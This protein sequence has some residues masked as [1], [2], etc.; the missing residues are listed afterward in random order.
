MNLISRN[1]KRFKPVEHE[2][3]VNQQCQTQN[4]PLLYSK[5]LNDKL[6]CF[7]KFQALNSNVRFVS[8][9]TVMKP[10]S[11]LT[12]AN[13]IRV[14]V[15]RVPIVLEPSPV[16]IL[17]GVMCKGNIA[18]KQQDKEAASRRN[19]ATRGSCLI[20]S[21]NWAWPPLPPSLITV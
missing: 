3:E 9:P 20:L 15:F 1:C 19:S 4:P 16:T 10:I 12:F 17:Y 18:M 13:G 7:F 11:E 14:S 8:V 21:V 2:P 6:N 5:S